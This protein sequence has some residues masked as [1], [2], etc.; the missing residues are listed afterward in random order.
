VEAHS[1][2]VVRYVITA[3]H[4][5]PYLPPCGN[6]SSYIERTYRPLLGQLGE[7]PSVWAELLFA[8]PIADVA[9]LGPPDAGEMAEQ[10]EGYEAL[11]E[12]RQA[13]WIGDLSEDAPV[14][15]MHLDGS[16]MECRAARGPRGL[17][18]SGAPKGL[19]SGMSGSP[20]L[21]QEGR[22][23]GVFVTSGGAPG[24]LHTE[25]GP[26]VRLTTDLPA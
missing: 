24:E 8:D 10:R 22:A 3:A 5:L 19:V 11:V 1:L 4:C 15:L 25:G 7:A 26:Q 2:N 6:R 23:V 21:S 14:W 18:L 9:I 12:G 13:L 17:G 16:W 20:I